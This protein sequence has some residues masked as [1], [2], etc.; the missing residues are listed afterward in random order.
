MSTWWLFYQQHRDTLRPA[1]VDNII[2]ILSCGLSVRGYAIFRCSN[3]KCSHT[4][5]IYFSCKGRF[6]PTCG[7]KLTEQWI[8]KQQTI[9][10]DPPWQ[11]ITFTMPGEL[12]ELFKLNRF[13]LND[14]SR[15]SANTLLKFAKNKG[16]TPGIFTALHTFGRDLKWNT[17]VHLSITLGG[18][19]LDHRLWTPLYFPQQSIKKRGRYGIIDL[20]Q[21]HYDKLIFPESLQTI[22]ATYSGFTRW[23]DSHYQKT[24][25]VHFAKPNK[26][27]KKNVS[28]L[29]RYI[30]RP[31][32]AMSRLEHYD[33]HKVIFNYS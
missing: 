19:T 7:K 18:L 21:K 12:W 30:K 6:C 4:K 2:K 25:I 5:R 11:H 13:L 3:D 22:G 33:G 14:L 15:L 17:H 23:L 31:P 28:Y 8:Q 20:L 1:I 24:W 9:L 27:H 29:G 10:P 32:L 16:I 26:N